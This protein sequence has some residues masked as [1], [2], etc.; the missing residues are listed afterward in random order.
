MLK[1]K[2]WSITL[3][4]I[5]GLLLT[6]LVFSQPKPISANYQCA[7]FGLGFTKDFPDQVSC[8]RIPTT[9]RVTVTASGSKKFVLGRNYELWRVQT[10]QAFIPSIGAKKISTATT[11]NP[12]NIVFVISD[13]AF[14]PG[15]WF[16][17]IFDGIDLGALRGGCGI[18]GYNKAYT[19]SARE[20]FA[21]IY[22]TQNRGGK[23]CY[24]FPNGCLEAGLP[25]TLTVENIKLCGKPY[26]NKSVA[27]YNPLMSPN[28][29]F[30]QTDASGTITGSP[31]TFTRSDAGYTEID[32]YPQ[33]FPND[34][35]LKSG[36]TFNNVSSCTTCNTTKP[37]PIDPNQP[38]EYKICD[39][40]N[41]DLLTPEGGSAKDAC[42]QCVGGNELGREGIWTAIG[43]IPRDPEKIVKSLLRLGLGMGGG[44]ALIII[45][46]SG[47]VLSVSQGEP[48]RINEAKQWLTSALV[49]LLFIIFSVTLLH[50]IGYTIFKIPGFG[51]S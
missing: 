44:F 26:A 27:I 3:R 16:L 47:F 39:Q 30:R 5:L 45:L 33:E 43:C 31:I 40:I 37:K 6:V 34:I 46:A 36:L 38:Y 29:I 17:T 14:E 8:S 41:G 4:L 21:G 48:N 20:W 32:I 1:S 35:I 49:G 23:M 13:E 9:A 18:N 2:K 12:E 7:D 28:R 25:T 24:G 15:D 11:T 50:F 42:L 19:V 10:A 22:L 51:G